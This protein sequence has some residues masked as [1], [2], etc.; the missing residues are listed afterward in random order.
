MFVKGCLLGAGS[1]KLCQVQMAPILVRPVEVVPGRQVSCVCIYVCTCA[2]CMCVCTWGRDMWPPTWLLPSEG[3]NRDLWAS[4]TAAAAAPL[5][6]QSSGALENPKRPRRDAERRR[7]EL[8]GWPGSLPSPTA[9]SLR[10]HGDMSPP[11][12]AAG[13]EPQSKEV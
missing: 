2:C 4:G 11:L 3:L 10:D 6:M 8:L 9:L 1:S 13:E 7:E 12:P 5:L